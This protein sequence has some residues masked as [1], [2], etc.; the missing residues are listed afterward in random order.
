MIS[1]NPWLGEGLSSEVHRVSRDKTKH[2][3]E[4]GQVE[5]YNCIQLY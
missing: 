1:P 3:N 4:V 5:E 2:V